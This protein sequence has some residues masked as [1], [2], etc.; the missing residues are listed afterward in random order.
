MRLRVGRKVDGHNK[1]LTEQEANR[2]S[3]ECGFDANKI[4]CDG[5]ATASL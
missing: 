2:W 4:D 5:Q 1:P 3:A